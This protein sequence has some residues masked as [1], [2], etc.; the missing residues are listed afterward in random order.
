M[1]AARY[2]F[3]LLAVC[4]YPLLLG[5]CSMAALH[6]IVLGL[7][8]RRSKVFSAGSCCLQAWDKPYAHLSLLLES[9]QSRIKPEGFML[10][11]LFLCA[12]GLAGGMMLF[13]QLQGQPAIRSDAWA[14]SVSFSPIGAYSSADAGSDGFFAGGGVVYNA[15]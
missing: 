1:L 7:N 12:S 2:P 5:M 10:L 3:S 15:T 9:L 8:Y 14:Y 6:G 11:S 13:L 4:L